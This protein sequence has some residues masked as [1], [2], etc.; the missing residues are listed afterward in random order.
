M[1]DK[2]PRWPRRPRHQ[3][4]ITFRLPNDLLLKRL[5]EHAANAGVDRSGYIRRALL[6]AMDS[7]EE[8]E[9]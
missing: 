7:D 8:G 1:T 9:S 6:R 5:D 3:P 4:T 2:V